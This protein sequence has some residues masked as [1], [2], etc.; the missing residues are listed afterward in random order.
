MNKMTVTAPV[1][2]LLLQFSVCMA[3]EVTANHAQSLKSPVIGAVAGGLVAGPPGLVAGLISGVLIGHIEEQNDQIL[4]AEQALSSVNGQLELLS[5]QQS[6]QHARMLEQSQLSR[7]RLNAVAEGF[8]FCLRFRTESAA[9]EP[10]LQ[11]HLD[12]LAGMLNVFTELDVEVR[13]SA[14]RHGS[15]N[16]NQQLA[17]LRADAVAQR[18]IDAGV[19]V[20]RIKL[21]VIGEE[22]AIYPENDP[23]GLD[24]DRYVVLSLLPG[25]AS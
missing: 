19:S 5:E 8:S 10:A 22:A 21:R 24:F 6:G 15:V 2:G 1:V 17:K 4:T 23:E 3:E 7:T 12:A 9:I 25:D 20:V 11:P 14:D 16:Y 13:A 18:L